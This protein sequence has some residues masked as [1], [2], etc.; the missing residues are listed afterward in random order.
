MPDN[1]IKLSQEQIRKMKHAIGLDNS[2]VKNGK[3]SAYRNHYSTSD[4]AEWN[5]MVNMG[6][7]TKRKDP[8]CANDV[9]YHVADKGISYL[10]SILGINIT[11]SD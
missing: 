4:D 11:I 7:A 10:S 2:K 3:Y 6:L 1:N 9:I 8:F 5:E